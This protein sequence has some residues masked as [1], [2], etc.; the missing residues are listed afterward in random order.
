MYKYPIPNSGFIIKGALYASD[1]P[2]ESLIGIDEFKDLDHSV[3][4]FRLGTVYSEM[5]IICENER[6]LIKK[7]TS[8]QPSEVV[9]QP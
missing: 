8:N 7:S 2:I 9:R 6:F 1:Y 4:L 3:P 5:G